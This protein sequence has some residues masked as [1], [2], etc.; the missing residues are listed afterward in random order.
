MAK[1]YTLS[2]NQYNKP[3]VYSGKDAIMVKVQQLLNM[4]PGT[5]PLH[6]EMGVDLAHRYVYGEEDDLDDLQTEIEKQIQVYL[7]DLATTIH[8]TCNINNENIIETNINIDDTLFS[9]TTNEKET[10]IKLED[11]AG[12]QDEI[13]DDPNENSYDDQD[14]LADQENTL[15]TMDDNEYSFPYQSN[16]AYMTSRPNE[17]MDED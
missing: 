10:T 11:M 1:E 2:T 17:V 16:D 9:F 13:P 4:I 7:P 8:V 6:P 12:E 5:N 15:N 3:H 14:Y